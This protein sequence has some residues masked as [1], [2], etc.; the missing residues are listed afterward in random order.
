M[1]HVR[2]RVRPEGREVAA[3]LCCATRELRMA[4]LLEGGQGENC[5][6]MKR[7]RKGEELLDE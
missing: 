4:L 3:S 5:Q 2:K 6:C 7:D 1:A